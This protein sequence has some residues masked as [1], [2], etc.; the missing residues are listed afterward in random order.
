MLFVVS[1]LDNTIT[2]LADPTRRR[3]IEL[4]RERPRK[5]GDLAAE[6]SVTAPAVSRHLRIL[7]R[8]G[9]IF[10]YSPDTDARV[11]VYQLRRE[12]LL[13]LRTWV[14]QAQAAA[15]AAGRMSGR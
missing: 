5:A 10:E 1:D 7:R 8:S 11:R 9:L 12:P 3:I 6:F 2:A 14:D 4:L 15:V 13:A